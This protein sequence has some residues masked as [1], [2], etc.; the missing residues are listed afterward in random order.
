MDRSK[1][2]KL[3]VIPFMLFVGV[4]FF[5]NT[6]FLIGFSPG[7][8]SDY[9]FLKE[10]NMN[11]EGME[12]VKRAMIGGRIEEAKAH[13]IQY[14]DNNLFSNPSPLVAA[15]DL[16]VADDILNH[17]FVYQDAG[18]FAGENIE[19]DALPSTDKE[20][21]W[22]L[23]RHYWASDLARAYLAT[24]DEKYAREFVSL[25]LDFYHDQPYGT[26][27][28][29]C[30]RQKDTTRRV[31]NHLDA[32]EVFMNSEAFT[33]DAKF[34]WYKFIWEQ[35]YF[36]SHDPE[37]KGNGAI[38]CVTALLRC[39]V[40]FPEMKDAP[41]WELKAWS[42]AKEVTRNQLLPDGVHDELSTH[43]HNVVVDEHLDYFELLLANDLEIDDYMYS[44]VE[45]ALNFTM[46]THTV[47]GKTMT[48]NDADACDDTNLLE[49]GAVIYNRSDF[50]YI[51][52]SG[53]NG[54]PPIYN[55]KAY[56]DA[57]F[58]LMRSGRGFN[59]TFLMFDGGPP[60]TSHIHHDLLSFALDA[61]G[62]NLLLDPGRGTYDESQ[63]ERNYL[64]SSRAH[65]LFMLDGIPL[66]GAIPDLAKWYNAPTAAFASATHSFWGDSVSRH[67]LYPSNGRDYYVI[68]DKVHGGTHLVE[69]Q[70]HFHD[71]AV[72]ATNNNHSFESTTASTG[73]IKSYCAQTWNDTIMLVNSTNP[74]GGIYSPTYNNYQPAT[75]VI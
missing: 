74:M 28:S 21:T 61:F 71:P 5:L 3:L 60:G 32:Y 50:L 33:T 46:D 29:L 55:N 30:W 11:H 63:P 25:F 73:Y 2:T 22:F 68:L 57:G 12:D 24:S 38:M 66:E 42:I 49:R 56:K 65:N 40:A 67:I 7:H 13:F 58:F 43:Y 27:N 6:R 51:A 9:L 36:L 37:K 23:N 35:A 17:Y 53:V 41:Y 70:F 4:T 34:K 10:M 31:R 44:R 19:W 8:N 16:T 1:I 72:L 62:T 59:S 20:W 18:Y 52:T 47:T 75:T 15:S 48:F 69:N 26:S 39:K 64:R 14:K 54:T 45:D